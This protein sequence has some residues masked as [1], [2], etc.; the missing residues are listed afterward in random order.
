MW[1]CKDYVDREGKWYRAG[2]LVVS[3]VM[4]N[5]SGSHVPDWGAVK[6]CIMFMGTWKSAGHLWPVGFSLVPGK[7]AV[8]Y[9][10]S[11]CYLA[12][13]ITAWP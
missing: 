11:V 2:G 1:L 6:R 9:S 4:S 12:V 10:T 13:C 5:C 7:G 8:S 3:P